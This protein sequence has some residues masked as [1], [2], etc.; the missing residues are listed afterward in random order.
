MVHGVIAS[1]CAACLSMHSLSCSYA[2]HMYAIQC[3]K[4]VQA[5]AAVSVIAWFYSS[6]YNG[7]SSKQLGK[8][9]VALLLD[10]I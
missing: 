2:Q 1:M 5:V 6:D 4:T 9:G 7:P 10:M 3:A 8:Q